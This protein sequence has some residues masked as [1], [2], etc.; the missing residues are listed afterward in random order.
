MN[1]FVGKILW[2]KWICDNV[3]LNLFVAYAKEPT[4]LK[5]KTDNYGYL[6]YVIYSYM[7]LHTR[8]LSARAL[9][10][11]VTLLIPRVKWFTFN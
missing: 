2:W 10:A 1:N 6:R 8:A 3:V 11:L 9:D 7:P 5:I 4:Q